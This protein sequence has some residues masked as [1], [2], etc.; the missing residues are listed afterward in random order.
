L[1]RLWRPSPAWLGHLSP[2]SEVLP[3]RSRNAHT[4]GDDAPRCRKA[5]L[6]P[7]SYVPM[8]NNRH[9]Y[10]EQ[11]DQGNGEPLD[12]YGFIELLTRV[13]GK[14]MVPERLRL[15][16]GWSLRSNSGSRRSQ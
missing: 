1:P 6:R 3:H 11:A 9:N 2:M 10:N 5:P 12:Y 8:T 4:S 13:I 14:M 7:I 15:L 16:G